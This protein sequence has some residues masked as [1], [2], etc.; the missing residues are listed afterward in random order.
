MR[1][2]VVHGAQLKCSYGTLPGVLWVSAANSVD[3]DRQC[4]ATV[5]D[6]FPSTN[7]IT[8]GQCTTLGN[9]SVAAMTAAAMGTPT[10]APCVPVITAPWTPGAPAVTINHVKVLT[11]DSTCRCAW[12][13]EIGITDAGEG[14]IELP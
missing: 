14:S 5:N 10:P 11:D 7:V 2:L 1:K 13:G 6:Y 3:G 8:F 4:A 12:N 9:P